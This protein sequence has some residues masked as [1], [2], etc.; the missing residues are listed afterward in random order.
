LEKKAVWRI[1]L[2]ILFTV[3]MYVI[4]KPIEMAASTNEGVEYFIKLSRDSPHLRGTTLYLQSNYTDPLPGDVNIVL[5]STSQLNGHATSWIEDATIL[6]DKENSVYKMWVLACT[7]TAYSYWSVYY[8]ESDSLLNWS[9][10]NIQE[11]YYGVSDYWDITR[12]FSISVLKVSDT[13]Y[14]M[15]FHIYQADGWKC[16]IWYRSSA[17]GIT[18]TEPQLVIGAATLDDYDWPTALHLRSGK[19][20]L[21]TTYTYQDVY[22][23]FY[24]YRADVEPD[25]TT[26]S[27]INQIAK[28]PCGY[29]HTVG[30]T[31]I[32]DQKGDNHHRIWHGVRYGTAPIELLRFDSFDEGQSWAV[33]NMGTYDTTNYFIVGTFYEA[34]PGVGGV[35]VPVDKLGLLAPYIAYASTILVATAAT[36]IY[37][38]RVK[39]R[40]ENQ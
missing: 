3:A 11:C 35:V 30:A 16:Q 5:L 33:T 18:W 32:G 26:T 23:F 15:W 7:G 28:I 2:I 34:P 9:V 39:R 37:V 20:R 38:K 4:F 31:I 29:W 21:Y 8:M 19:Y 24:L 14:K 6:Y 22:D 36:S 1:M 12:Q 10:K 13:S 40:K 25:G 17:D 27:N